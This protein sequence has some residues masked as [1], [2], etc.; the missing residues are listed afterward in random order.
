MFKRKAFEKLKYWKE[1]KAPHYAALLEG[2]RRVGKTTIA[3]EFARTEYK[4]YIMVDFANV[5]K[6][7]LDVFDD[8]ANLNLFFSETPD[9]N[10]NYFA[11]QGICHYI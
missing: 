5:R 2:A 3:E 11:Y 4:S 1:N 6:E 8:I 9:G 10:R 7:V